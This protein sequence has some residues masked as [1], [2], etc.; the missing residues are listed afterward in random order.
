MS[1]SE[2]CDES[3]RGAKGDEEEVVQLP[4]SE[5]DLDMSE[6]HCTMVRR[7][8]HHTEESSPSGLVP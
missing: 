3:Y 2:R 7:L 5:V 6:E 4:G 1:H 8:T